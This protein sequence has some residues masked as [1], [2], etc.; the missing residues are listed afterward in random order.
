[1]MQSISDHCTSEECSHH[2]RHH[3]PTLIP[4]LPLGLGWVTARFQ[5]N[6]CVLDLL[7]EVTK[8]KNKIWKTPIHF[9][10]NSIVNQR[11]SLHLAAQVKRSN[12]KLLSRGEER[13]HQNILLDSFNQILSILLKKKFGL[14]TKVW[15]SI[16]RRPKILAR[17]QTS[18]LGRAF[19]V[20]TWCQEV[21]NPVRTY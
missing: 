7:N 2:C 21:L 16:L 6:Q 1:M 18:I 17:G 8:I 3:L 4:K 11:S 15:V 14:S 20:P 10:Y 19:K 9:M 13:V 12:S 5:L